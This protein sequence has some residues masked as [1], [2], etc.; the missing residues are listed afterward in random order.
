MNIF[1]IAI[2]AVAVLII[3]L[4]AKK[5]FVA[6]CLDSFSM[7]I[8]AFVS[9]K[10]CPTVANSM[11]D[12]FIKDLVKTEFR[13]ALDEMSGS[14][15]VREKVAGMIDALP[16][17]AVKLAQS[18]GIDVNNMSSI[19]VSGSASNETLIDT[20]A[21]TLAYDILITLTEI[22]VFIALFIIATLLVRFISTFFSH[23][24][25]KLPFVGKLDSLLGG[26]LGVVKALVI[27]FAGS[28]VLY[29]VAQTADAGSPLESIKSSQIYMFMVEYNPIIDILNG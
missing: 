29:I 14:L 10:L 20:I 13:Q 16:E 11:Y 12:M 3:V 8:S 27:V 26:A 24:L 2:I 28:V 19:L 23:N 5:G 4:S 7:V 9:Y 22:I 25:E 1:D 21:D 6:T 18:M 15:S 17:T